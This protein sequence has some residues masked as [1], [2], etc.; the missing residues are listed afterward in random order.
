MLATVQGFSE[1]YG[2]SINSKGYQDQQRY[3]SDL[4]GRAVG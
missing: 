1:S 3:Q 4:R 2:K